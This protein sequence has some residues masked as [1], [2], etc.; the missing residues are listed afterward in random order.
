MRVM[1]I[2]RDLFSFG[3]D[4]TPFWFVVLMTCMEDVARLR[5]FSLK[6]DG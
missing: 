2:E 6:R 3:G 1:R 5:D 4:D